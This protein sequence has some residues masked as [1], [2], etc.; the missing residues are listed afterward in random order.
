LPGNSAASSLVKNEFAPVTSSGSPPAVN[1]ISS[2]I[3]KRAARKDILPQ[4]D[5]SLLFDSD[6]R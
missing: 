4:D 1:L 6:G 3:A 5:F 2:M